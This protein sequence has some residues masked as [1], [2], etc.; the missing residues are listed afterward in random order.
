VDTTGRTI[1]E[2]LADVEETL[3]AHG[4]LSLGPAPEQGTPA[5]E[6]VD[7]APQGGTL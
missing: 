3:A 7:N 1:E 2:A 4:W 6:P 5:A